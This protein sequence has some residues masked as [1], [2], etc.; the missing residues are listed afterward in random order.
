[1]ER[2]APPTK[3]RNPAVLIELG[4]KGG[5]KAPPMYN[6]LYCQEPKVRK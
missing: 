2:A 3:Q 5:R 6:V 4:W 1:M